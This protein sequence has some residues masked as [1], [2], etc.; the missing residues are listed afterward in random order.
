MGLSLQGISKSDFEDNAFEDLARDI[1]WTPRTKRTSNVTGSVTYTSSTDVTIKGIF[2]KK[3]IKYNWDKEGM[4]QMGD[5]FLQ[6]KEN[7]ELLKDDYITVDDE[8]YRV[9][10]VLLRSPQGI[11]FFK[12]VVLFRVDAI[13][14]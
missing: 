10:D 5:A 11:R 2:T 6:I 1:V 8:I 7:V 4:L 14:E 12:S 9:D 3:N 13:G